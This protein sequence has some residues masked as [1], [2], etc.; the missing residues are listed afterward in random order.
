VRSRSAIVGGHHG[1]SRLPYC[2]KQ[3]Y[4]PAV[5]VISVANESAEIRA[6]RLD[7]KQPLDDKLMNQPAI[8]AMISFGVLAG[9]TTPSQRSASRFGTGSQR[10]K[11]DIRAPKGKAGLDPELPSKILLA[12]GVDR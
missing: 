8:S 2:A 10:A 12:R 4:D 1:H 3:T 6:A 7:R 9:A 5:F 11:G